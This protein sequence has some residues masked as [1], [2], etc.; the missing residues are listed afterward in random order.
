MEI[1]NACI[2]IKVPSKSIAGLFMDLITII[3]IIFII[4]IMEKVLYIIK[5]NKHSK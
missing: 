1:L 5:N 4:I 3:F 2:V